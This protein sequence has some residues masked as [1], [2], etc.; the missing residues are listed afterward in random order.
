MCLGTQLQERPRNC[1]T[2]NTAYLRRSWRMTTTQTRQHSC[3]TGSLLCKSSGCCGLFFAKHA[4]VHDKNLA[5][6]FFLSKKKKFFFW[7]L[8]LDIVVYIATPLYLF[9]SP[10]PLLAPPFTGRERTLLAATRIVWQRLVV[11]ISCLLLVWHGGFFCIELF[12]I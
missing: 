4:S 12:Y 9:S 2:A 10:E 5:L 7:S 6:I 11:D 3:R 8:S 1:C